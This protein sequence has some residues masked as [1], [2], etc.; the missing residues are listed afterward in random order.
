LRPGDK[1][2][3]ELISVSE[4][5]VGMEGCLTVV[6]T[7]GL[8]AGELSAYIEELGDRIRLRDLP[9]MLRAIHFAIPEYLPST[10]ICEQAACVAGHA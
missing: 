10:V 8:S 7:P 9:G 5:K 2:S 4:R 3:E 6:E 1:L